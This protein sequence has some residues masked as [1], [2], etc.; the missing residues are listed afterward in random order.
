MKDFTSL[1][2]QL[3]QT[4]DTPYPLSNSEAKLPVT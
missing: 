1:P 3:K 4:E 2:A